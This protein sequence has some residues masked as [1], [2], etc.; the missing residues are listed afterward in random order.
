MNPAF[1][2]DSTQWLEISLADRT[3]AWQSSRSFSNPS[4]CWSA[5]LNQLTL[6]A[7]LP[8]LQ[9]ESP[10]AQPYPN[11]AALPSIWEVVNGTAIAI[12]DLRVVLIPSQAADLDELRV[13]QEWV[14][15][16]D[17]AADFYLAVQVKPDEGWIH[18]WGGTSHDRLKT[19]GTFESRDR[20][21]C[22][23]EEDLIR[24]WNALFVARE[25]C[26]EE[27]M[28]AAIE[29]LPLLTAPQAENLL[30]R[31]G[32]PSVVLPRLQVPFQLWGALLQH[33]GWRQQLCDRRQGRSEQ[34][35]ILEWLRAGVSEVAQQVGWARINFQPSLGT[36]RGEAGVAAGLI[37]HLTI[38]QQAYDLRITPQGDPDAQTWRFELYP[39]DSQQQIPAGFTLRL[40]TADLQP[41]PKNEAIATTAT[42]QLYL[43]VRLS[44]GDALVWEIEPTPEG[45][46]REILQF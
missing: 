32:S 18:V 9:E 11:A 27:A 15:L 37:R 34:W 8:W 7:F 24:N 26:P 10:Q 25:V 12:E 1:T 19:V 36:A 31:L 21:Y 13:P 35:S 30:Q 41:F 45:Y 2:A 28:R 22:L 38:D 39:A 42:D 43:R 16:P 17:W 14:D 33:G 5:Y 29:P 40:L 4:Q 3:Q 46:E 6:S 44:V 23:E 20:T